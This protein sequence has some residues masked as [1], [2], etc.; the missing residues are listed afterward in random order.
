MAPRVLAIRTL[1]VAWADHLP[2]PCQFGP[3]LAPSRST[4]PKA[5]PFFFLFFPRVDPTPDVC[6]NDLHVFN[7]AQKN[8]YQP[9]VT[10]TLPAP[11]S[12]HSA[13]LV[14]DVLVVFGGWDQPNAIFN[15][16]HILDITLMECGKVLLA[17]DAPTPRSWHASVALP[18]KRQVLIHGGLDDDIVAL[19]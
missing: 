6:S 5:I 17:G 19:G 4:H 14:D 15:D 13:T 11:R 3:T 16:V 9:P 10:G 8:W 1:W 7:L 2:A 12:G 18:G